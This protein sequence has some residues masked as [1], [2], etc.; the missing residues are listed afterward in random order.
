MNRRQRY[1]WIT[2][3]GLLLLVGL[4]LI[5]A[6]RQGTLTN[7]STYSRAPGGYGAWYAYME[8]QGTPIQRWEKPLSLFFDQAE[9]G[10]VPAELPPAPITLM[11]IHSDFAPFPSPLVYDRAWL[12]RGNVLVQ[13]GLRARVRNVPFQQAIATPQGEVVIETRRRH[14]L[15]S[16]YSGQN[17]SE[18]NA[19]S[20]LEDEGG[21]IAWE[22]KVGDGRVIFIVTPHLAA[23]AYQSAPGNFEFLATLL[24]EIGYPIYVDEYLH[25]YKDEGTLQTEVQSSLWVYLARTPIALIAA[26][27]GILLLLLIWGLNRRL[28]PP[29][30]VRSPPVDNNRAY[31]EA[32]ASVLRTANSTEFVV[33]TLGKAERL[34]LQ[35]A[36]G[37]GNTPLDPALL[38]S[39]WET[40]TGR[41]PEEVRPLL[42]PPNPKTMT[43]ADL[44]RWLQHL[45]HL[46][47]HLPI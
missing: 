44:Q 4:V 41:S 46:H 17:Q 26:Q 13:L 5:L 40:Q 8:Q 21:A 11:Q 16:S 45:A 6:P 42:Y 36:L 22:E 28:G 7:G 25:G 1:L 31:M 10:S 19:Q 24:A 12:E 15:A 3:L 29:N 9:D 30:P 35:R 23:N 43:E 32:L 47:P 20:L 18:A 39:A 37:F 34:N 38:S 2:G 14:A 33:E 27:A